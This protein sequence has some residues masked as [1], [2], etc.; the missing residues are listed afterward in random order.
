MKESELYLPIK[1]FFIENGYKVNGEVGDIDMV[2]TKDDPIAI[3]LKPTF[4]LKLILQA[5]D[6]QKMFDSVYVAIFRP[7]KLN[8]RYKEMIHLLKRLELGLIS[9]DILKSGTRV[10]IE[11]HPI[12][13]ERKKNHKKKRA[14]INEIA[15]RTGIIDNIGGTTKMK[16]VTAYR[17]QAIG[18]LYVLSQYENASPK[19]IKD[20]LDHDK[21]GSILYSNFYQ[22]FERVDKGSYRV[23]SKGIEA[24]ELYEPIV[25]YYKNKL[26]L[27]RDHNETDQ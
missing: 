14:I 2:V 15:N 11:H 26:S 1:A 18:V 13:L 5:V 19:E 16:R 7:A 23:S 12:A 24:L 9:V 17:E 25:T 21:V 4:N 3:E 8:K 27:E 10:V 20:I 22:W 6:R